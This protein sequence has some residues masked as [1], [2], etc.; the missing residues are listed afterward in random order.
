MPAIQAITDELLIAAVEAAQSR[1]LVIAPGVCAP[2]A[3]AIAD[4]W[5][6]LG[7]ERVTVILDVDP[8]ICRI[9]YGEFKGLKILQGAAC[10]LNEAVGQ[11]SGV[12]ICVFIIDDQTFIFSPTPRQLEQ[13]PGNPVGETGAVSPGSPGVGDPASVTPPQVKAN[14]IILTSPPADLE[15]DLGA[16]PD[17]DAGRKLGL[18]P[19]NET[20]LKET[21]ADLKRDPPKNFDLSRAVRVYNAK[22]QF[23]ELKVSGCKLSKHEATLPGHL[24]HV[25]RKNPEL[26]KKIGKSIRLIDEDDEI[27]KDPKLSETTISASRDKIE[28]DF[29]RP[30]TGVG[31]VIERCKKEEFL[32]RVETL[33]Q[34]VSNFSKSV[35]AKLAE[36]FT[37]T[38]RTLADE[39]LPGVL[40]DIPPAW[41]RKLGP[42]P[43]PERVR[44]LI[45]EAL[46]QSFGTPATRVARMNVE[47]VF[48]DVTYDMLTDPDFQK[49]VAEHFPD[50]PVMERYNAAPEREKAPD[51]LL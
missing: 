5:H 24:I 3:G 2:L 19:L 17:G 32:G 29:L 43:D 21:A 23:V 40:G 31:K 25:L 44:W 15:S 41:R 38:A 9:G 37:A 36:R 12:R 7:K 13:P 42:N 11:E 10:S 51:Q 30:V 22:I 1:V 27:V 48:K 16:G 26:E 39:L 45:A 14:G 46:H 8:E 33:K 6:R 49:E 34:E 4:A 50:L 20:K 18:E 28:K 47:V 35:E